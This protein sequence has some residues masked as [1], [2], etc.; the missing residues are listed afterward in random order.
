M[1]LQVHL[2]AGGI[3]SIE[4]FSKFSFIDATDTIFEY[5]SKELNE[6]SLNDQYTYNFIGESTVKINGCDIL[7]LEFI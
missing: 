2:K 7:Y 3:V 6:I 1:E 4:N 5:E